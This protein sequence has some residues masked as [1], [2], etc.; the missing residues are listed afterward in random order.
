MILFPAID[1]KGGKVV[2]L[3]NGQPDKSTVFSDDPLYVAHKWIDA[4]AKWLHI[5]DLDGAFS[6]KSLN[7][8]HKIIR[9]IIS[10]IDIP[11]QL[12]GGI[13]TIDVVKAWMDIGV[14]RLI[15]GTMVIENPNM[16]AEICTMF[17]GKIG[18][19]IDTAN[20]FVKTRGWVHNSEKTCNDLIKEVEDLGAAFIIH[21]DIARDGT[22]AGV[23]ADALTHVLSLTKLPVIVAGGIA[24][25]EDVV[26]IYG[27]SRKY[28]NIEG[29]ITGKAIYDGSLSFT[30]ASNW[31]AN[32]EERG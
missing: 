24:S 10:N 1:L 17:P 21:T 29:A 11:I 28:S 12:G 13:R 27:L 8:N 9:E 22:Q 14:T 15:I 16:F 3:L 30:E 32:N 2:R 23:N 26:L 18:V 6:G 5:V 4:G 25:M 7:M 20:G 19:S 31:I